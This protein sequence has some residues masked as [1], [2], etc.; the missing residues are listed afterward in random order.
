M[1]Y[2]PMG[3]ERAV[4]AYFDPIDEERKR[5]ARVRDQMFLQMGARRGLVAGQKEIAEHAAQI[6]EGE[7]LAEVE[8]RKKT[9]AFLLSIM[10]RGG[11]QPSPTDP[12]YSV[13]F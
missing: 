1:A 8:R 12:R 4:K 9:G 7:R 2:R 13:D 5:A 3:L 6:R 10:D 11:R